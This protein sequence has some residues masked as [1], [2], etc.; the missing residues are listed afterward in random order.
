[1]YLMRYVH[2]F[3]SFNF[4]LKLMDVLRVL[5]YKLFFEFFMGKDKIY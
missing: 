3:L 2:S 4:F 1:M 5:V